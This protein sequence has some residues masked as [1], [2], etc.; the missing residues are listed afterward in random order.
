MLLAV[1]GW[2]ETERPVGRQTRNSIL[3]IIHTASADWTEHHVVGTIDSLL[4]AEPF[5]QGGRQATASR[6]TAPRTR[7]QDCLA[8]S[9]SQALFTTW[10]IDPTLTGRVAIEFSVFDRGYRGERVPQPLH[11]VGPSSRRF[12]SGSELRSATKTVRV[13]RSRVLAARTVHILQRPTRAGRLPDTVAIQQSRELRSR[14]LQ[15]VRSDT[16]DI[17]NALQMRLFLGIRFHCAA[18]QRHQVAVTHLDC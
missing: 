11:S 3:R 9:L 18:T 12:P 16:L 2:G 7:T 8:V 13:F 14:H 6:S 1:A 15:V 5:L 4:V 10:P 17:A